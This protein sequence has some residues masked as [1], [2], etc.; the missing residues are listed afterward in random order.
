MATSCDA[1]EKKESPREREGSGEGRSEDG[2]DSLVAR[3]RRFHKSSSQLCAHLCLKIRERIE[4]SASH[5]Q[6]RYENQFHF[7]LICVQRISHPAF[8][9]DAITT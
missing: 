5:E 9:D 1:R 8:V 3:A 4:L 6:L 2:G 7:S